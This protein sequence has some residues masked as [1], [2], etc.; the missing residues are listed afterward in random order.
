MRITWLGHSS[1]LLDVDGVR[2]LADPLLR[3]RVGILRRTEPVPV[4]DALGP[5]GVEAVLLSHLHDDHCDLPSIRRLDAPVVVAPPGAGR[6]LAARGVRGVAELNPGT[7]MAIGPVLVHAVRAEH[8][9]RRRPWGPPAGA[10]GHVV[11][12]TA[13]AWLAGDTALHD[14]MRSVSDIAGHPGPDV[15]VL[16]VWGWGPRL[17]PGHMNP[18]QA[19]EAALL[20]RARHAVPVHWG[21]LF[22]VGMRGVMRRR[23]V[24]P[25]PEFAAAVAVLGEHRDGD[26]AVLPRVSVLPVGGS[27]D[28]AGRR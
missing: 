4:S 25:G 2:L 8:D 16:P 23:L 18:G 6:W 22:P 11:T 3:E 28:I 21:T 17:G 26:L 5:G 20:V 9:G 1:V 15:A 12:G 19:A 10:V 7:S 24:D 14:G 27:L 13:S